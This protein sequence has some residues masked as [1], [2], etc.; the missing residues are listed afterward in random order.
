VAGQWVRPCSAC[1]A[2]CRATTDIQASPAQP[3]KMAR[4]IQNDIGW[5]RTECQEP[6]HVRVHGPRVAV[7]DNGGTQGLFGLE[8]IVAFPKYWRAPP[9]WL[10]FGS[11]PILAR[12]APARARPRLLFAKSRAKPRRGNR[13]PKNWQPN[14]ARAAHGGIKRFAHFFPHPLHFPHLISST[15][16]HKNKRSA[17]SAGCSYLQSPV[18]ASVRAAPVAAGA[19]PPLGLISPSTHV[20]V[21]AQI[22]I[23]PHPNPLFSMTDLVESWA[24]M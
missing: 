18:P 20:K 23:E 22:P 11:L 8:P 9:V 7:A 14:L 12:P 24:E 3:S 6:N 19:A 16:A 10:Q 15:H 2:G 17:R 21:S 13:S 4:N 5:A 1:S